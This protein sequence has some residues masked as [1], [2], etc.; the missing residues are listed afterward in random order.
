METLLYNTQRSPLIIPEYGRHVQI[1]INQI[2]E[3]KEREERN[4]MA[5][6]VIGIMGNMNPHL[7]DVPDFQ[8]KLWDQ[9]FIMSNFGLDVDCPFEKPLKEVLEQKPERLSYPQKTPKYRFYGNN[10]KSMITVAMGWED[11]DLKNALI[12]N[13]A[14][15]MKKCFLNWN[16]DTVQDEVILN[17]LLELSDQKLRVK[18]E[19]L[20]LTDAE[21]FLKFKSKN[22]NGSK[23]NHKQRNKRNNGRK[24]Y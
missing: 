13:I 23:S 5:S 21:E 20:P 9:L 3:T 19:D 15:H 4:K 12:L 2:M 17:H 14:N 10:I 24:R 16:K 11:G 18:E 22:G 6:A 8:H 1:M 7:R